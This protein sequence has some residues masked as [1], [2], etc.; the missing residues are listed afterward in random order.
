MNRLKRL[1]ATGVLTLALACTTFAGNIHTGVVT[2]PP[3]PPAEDSSTA[4]A[5]SSNAPGEI[6]TGVVQS[7][8]GTELIL[9]LL[10]ML[11]VY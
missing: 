8:L 5:D 3:P 9:T 11:S 7:E 2:S 1:S 10:Q 6:Q 4:D